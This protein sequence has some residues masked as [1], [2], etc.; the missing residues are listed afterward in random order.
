[1]RCTADLKVDKFGEGAVNT[2]IAK[3]IFDHFAGQ[4]IKVLSIQQCR[5]KIARVTFED[6]TAC[7]CVQLRGELDMGGVKVDVVPPPPPPPNWINVVVYNYP[8]DAPNAYVNDAL[9]HYG[10]IQSIRYQHWTNLPDVSTATR[11]VRINLRGC[12]PRFVMIGRYRCKVWYRGQPVYC[13]ICKEATHIAFNCPL[14]GKCLSCKGVGHFAPNC[15]TVC[16]KCH[17]GHASDSCPNRRGWER[18]P[19][20]E[21]DFQSVASDVDNVE[22][23][24]GAAGNVEPDV[25]AAGDVASVTRVADGDVDGSSEHVTDPVVSPVVLTSQSVSMPPTLIDK[26][27]NQLDELQSQPDASQG[28]FLVPQSQSVLA[29]LTQVV[30]EASEVLVSEVSADSAPSSSDNA[31]T[32]DV[33][34]AEPSVARKRVASEV[35]SSED[36]SSRSRSKARGRKAP[37]HPAPHVPPGVSSAALLAR[38]RS[39]SASRSTSSSRSSRK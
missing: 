38:S 26:R 27:F 21:D 25:G 39:N 18:A 33:S 28:Q 35:A 1:M 4:N 9:G 31:P 19:R 7:E 5:N 15:P 16:F 17:G 2:D 13:D 22:P 11:I 14:K 20:D 24:V 34:M 30:R 8:Y 3:A 32:H 29:G 37:K 12:I 6:Q 23:D 36:D 10:K